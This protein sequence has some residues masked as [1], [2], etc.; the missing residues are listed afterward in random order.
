MEDM[1]TYIVTHA[2]SGSRAFSVAVAS[3]KG[4]NGGR[5]TAILPGGF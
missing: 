4:G 3:V 5:L 1:A 2:D